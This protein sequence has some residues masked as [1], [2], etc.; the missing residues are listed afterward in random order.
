MPSG[1]MA[2]QGWMV[3]MIWLTLPIS[4]EAVR[5]ATRLVD[6]SP[7]ARMLS[8]NRSSRAPLLSIGS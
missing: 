4:E 5:S 8:A 1:A 6:V 3:G 2:I 7:S